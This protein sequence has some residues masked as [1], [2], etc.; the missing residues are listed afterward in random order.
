MLL[1]RFEEYSRK[2]REGITGQSAQLGLLFRLK[3]T[4]FTSFRNF[5]VPPNPR[6]N[7]HTEQQIFTYIIGFLDHHKKNGDTLTIHEIQIISHLSPCRD[8]AK[9]LAELPGALSKYHAHDSSQ[10]TYSIGSHGIFHRPT[11]PLPEVNTELSNSVETMRNANWRIERVNEIPSLMLKPADMNSVDYFMLMTKDNPA[12]RKK[13]A[14]FNHDF[15]KAVAEFELKEATAARP[16]A[17]QPAAAANSLMNP[18]PAVSS[19]K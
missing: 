12:L 6:L 9:K 7:E 17:S 18:S 14:S 19:P 16:A 4:L 8:C 10:A 2:E 13:I 5:T 3:G 15:R 1:P 11:S